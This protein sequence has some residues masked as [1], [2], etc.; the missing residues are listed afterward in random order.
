MNRTAKIVKQSVILAILVIVSTY[1]GIQIGISKHQ[2]VGKTLE[3]P[4]MNIILADDNP[5]PCALCR[6]DR[7]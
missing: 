2:V 7:G 5:K 3:K 1:L 4:S 6:K